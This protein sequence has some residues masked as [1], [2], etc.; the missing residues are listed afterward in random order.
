LQINSK[1]EK[2]PTFVFVII[3]CIACFSFIPVI[4]PK[5]LLNLVNDYPSSFVNVY[6]FSK[7]APTI[8]IINLSLL[9]LLLFLQ[10]KHVSIISKCVEHISKYD[11]TR[12]KSLIILII[13]FSFYLSYSWDELFTEQEIIFSDYQGVLEGTEAGVQLFHEKGINIYF[14][15]YALLEFSHEVL[16]NIRLVPF[17]SS[18]ALL[19]LTYFFTSEI[20][21]KRIT[22]LISVAILLQSNVFLL[23]D[24]IATYETTW[25]TF[26]LLSLFLV[27]KKMR[28]SFLAF[29]LSLLSKAVS[30]L[31]LPI[32]LFLIVKCNT[33]NKIKIQSIILYTVPFIIL[34][35][36]GGYLNIFDASERI[37]I[38]LK[39]F[40]AS[41]STFAAGTRF[42]GL[43]LSIFF[44][45]LYCLYLKS[46]K[47]DDYSTFLLF[48]ISILLIVPW[49][50][51]PILGFTNEP[52]RIIPLIT[53]FAISFGTL[54][55]LKSTIP[56]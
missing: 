1:F 9:S 25:I 37:D 52:Y 5:L 19:L 21:K 34:I 30:F 26:Y 18:F 56:K 32:T 20:S 12:K 4:F 6:E 31:F 48:S 54:F 55:S 3:L 51:S 15:R 50:I 29:I 49:I 33:A 22:G 39:K 8:I 44:P 16:E 41:V 11:V 2:L 36:L 53:F 13:L 14:V 23:F 47:Y 7:I 17:L 40:W 46:K 35:F 27:L 24:S 28:L 38:D 10:F 45:T 42:D 43:I